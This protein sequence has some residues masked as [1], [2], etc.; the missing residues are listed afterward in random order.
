MS[1]QLTSVHEVSKLFLALS[2]LLGLHSLLY[3][4]V[5]IWFFKPLRI[6]GTDSITCLEAPLEF[7]VEFIP[8]LD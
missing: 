5:S 6:D 7:T 4:L 3:V 2:S 1:R 8:M